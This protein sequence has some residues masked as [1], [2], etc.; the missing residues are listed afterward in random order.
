[1]LRAMILLLLPLFL[2]ATTVDAQTEETSEETSGYTVSFGGQYRIIADGANFDFHPR[3]VLGE[4]PSQS[5]VNQRF[6]TWLNLYDRAARNHGVYFQ[7]EIGHIV[8]GD[9]LDFPKTYEANG[10]EVGIELRRGYLWYKPS[11]RTLVRVGILDWHDRFGERPTFE[12]PMWA[13]DAYDSEQAPLANSVWDFNVGCVMFDLDTEERWHT[14][15]GA[16]VLSEGDTIGGDGSAV[17]FS[18]DLDR[19]VGSSLFG[20]S[21]YYLRDRGGYSYGDFGGPPNV[22]GVDRSWDLWLGARG[23]HTL[24]RLK[25]SYFFIWNRGKTEA[26]DW[27]HTGWAVKGNLDYEM[28]RTRF[29]LRT[30]YSTGNDHSSRDSSGE[31]RTIAQSV[32][33]TSA[34]KAIG[35]CW[36]SALP[37]AHRM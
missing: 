15:L 11:E 13:V 31:F 34:L 37:A 10:A 20:A 7:V 26:P 17:L 35:A 3:V 6:R 23:H 12:D 18:G 32:A 8:W 1:M 29:Q 5:F 2:L 24:G 14:S 25:P 16:V 28:G 36:A 30:L 19:E 22:G 27:E 33:T 21:A 9:D 4:Q